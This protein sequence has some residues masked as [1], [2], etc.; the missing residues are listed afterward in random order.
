[1]KSIVTLLFILTFSLGFAQDKKETPKTQI[2]EASCGQCQFG[3]KSK[4][5]CD[6]AVRMDGKSYFVEGTK[7]DDH[8][9]AH[10]EDGFCSAIRKAEVVGEVKDNKFVVSHFK[11]LPQKK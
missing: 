1:M 11:L 6:L 3:M 8:G 4:S 5:G 9:D 7:L 10:A 2:V